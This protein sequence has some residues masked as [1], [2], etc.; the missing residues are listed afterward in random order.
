M[1]KNCPRCGK[2]MQRIKWPTVGVLANVD[3]KMNS[4]SKTWNWYCGECK[5]SEQIKEVM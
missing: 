4:D 1:I 5:Y 3:N 2:P